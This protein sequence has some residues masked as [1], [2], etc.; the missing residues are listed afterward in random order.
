MKLSFYFSLEHNQLPMDYRR[1]FAS[2][3]KDALSRAD[4]SLFDYYYSGTYKIKPFTFSVYFD[5]EPKLVGQNIFEVGNQITLKFST[6]DKRL[7]VALFNGMLDLRYKPYKL[8]DN[9]ITL[10]SMM[11]HPPKK[12]DKDEVKFKTVEF[13]L[14]TNKNC[15]IDINDKQYDLYLTPN[16]IGFDEGLRFLVQEQVKKFLD[17]KHSFPF[18]YEINKGTLKITPVWH[19]NQ[20]N[21]SFKA[22]IKIKSH[23]KVLQLLYETG[24]G[25]RRSQGFGMLEVIE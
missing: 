11:L 17:Y 5:R 10:K 8:F 6:N 3:I 20:W 23:P 14:V 4:K 21:K 22:E 1:G 12:I 24:I 7:A 16:D 19:Y 25:A 2:I 18:D 13:T 9:Q 15:H